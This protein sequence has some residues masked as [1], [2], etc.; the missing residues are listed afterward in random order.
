MDTLPMELEGEFAALE[1]SS[2]KVPEVPEVAGVC[3]EPE[4][5]ADSDQPRPPV[6]DTVEPLAPSEQRKLFPKAKAKAKSKA[7]LEEGEKT[8]PGRRRKK[9]EPEDAKEEEKTEKAKEPRKRAS[10]K[11]KGKTQATDV[12]VDAPALGNSAPAVEPAPPK[13]RCKTS[14]SAKS[15]EPPAGEVPAT[16]E[17]A[18]EDL[19]TTA[20]ASDVT[21]ADATKKKPSRKSAAY[22]RARKQALLDGKSADEAK[23]CGKKVAWYC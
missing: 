15:S 9:S 22:H 4:A 8:K 7:K 5:L 18:P 1:I 19:S 10:R 14:K 2:P 21:A 12:A 20:A 3:S 13:K 23:E 11:G 6:L 17:V 16:G